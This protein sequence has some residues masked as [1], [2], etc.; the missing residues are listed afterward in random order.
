MAKTKSEVVEE[1]VVEKVVEK[2]SL[3]AQ[4]EEEGAHG[5]G[6]R[7]KMEDG[8]GDERGKMRE[9]RDRVTT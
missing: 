2:K 9:A 7:E 1:K 6:G 4:L 5:G 8:L 3:I